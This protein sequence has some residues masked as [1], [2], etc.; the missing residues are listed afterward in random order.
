MAAKLLLVYDVGD[1]T[2]SILGTSTLQADGNNGHFDYSEFVAISADSKN[3]SIS[4]YC[5][6]VAFCFS[7]ANSLVARFIN[8]RFVTIEW[9]VNCLLLDVIR[10]TLA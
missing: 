9:A 6:Y 3:V 2:K 7:V 5:S 8:R 1:G 10:S 4:L